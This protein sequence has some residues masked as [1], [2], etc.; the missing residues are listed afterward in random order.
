[1]RVQ[2]ELGIECGTDAILR[3][4]VGPLQGTKD[5]WLKIA[6]LYGPGG[7]DVRIQP[8][9]FFVAEGL[10]SGQHLLVVLED[11]K[12]VHMQSVNLQ[13]QETITIKLLPG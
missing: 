3:G 6:P 4:K 5:R 1:M 11:G 10:P 13:G 9:G 7:V 2:L 8:D 12:P